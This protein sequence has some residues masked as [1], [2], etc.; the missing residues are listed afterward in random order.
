M[1]L[2]QLANAAVVDWF[3]STAAWLATLPSGPLNELA[4]GAL[5]LVRRSLFNQLPTA[6]NSVQLA[7]NRVGQVS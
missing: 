1:D 5:L 6:G 2:P 4:S 3:D 7:T